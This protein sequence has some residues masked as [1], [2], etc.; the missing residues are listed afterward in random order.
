MMQVGRNEGGA[1][2]VARVGG[3]EREIFVCG[4][5]EQ[6]GLDRELDVAGGELRG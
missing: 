6:E 5:K 2:E 4:V 1:Y 3:R